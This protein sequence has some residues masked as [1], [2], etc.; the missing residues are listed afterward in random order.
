MNVGESR[1]S[2]GKKGVARMLGEKSGCLMRDL[3]VG[4]SA[5]PT[6]DAWR[7]GLAGNSFRL[8]LVLLW[9]K[10][11]QKWELSGVSE[12]ASLSASRG[13]LRGKKKSTCNYNQRPQQHAMPSPRER[14]TG[15]SKKVFIIAIPLKKKKKGAKYLHGSLGCLGKGIPVWFLPADVLLSPA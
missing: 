3:E 11:G 4:A 14:G 1:N 9:C 13:R 15:K 5:N 10:L 2:P 6:E 12:E 8:D 7:A